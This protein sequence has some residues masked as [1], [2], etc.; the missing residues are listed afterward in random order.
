MISSETRNQRIVERWEKGESVRSIAERYR[1]SAER[2]RQLLSEY[3]TPRYQDPFR[4][5]N[6]G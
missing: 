3:Q 6:A 4:R 5:S 2:V 1:I